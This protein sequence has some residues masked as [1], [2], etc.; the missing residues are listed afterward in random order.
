MIGRAVS[1]GARIPHY[2]GGGPVPGVGDP[3]YDDLI[4][5]FMAQGSTAPPGGTMLFDEISETDAQIGE[6]P[7]IPGMIGVDL[8]NKPLGDSSLV[9]PGN[10]TSN[11][12]I[13]FNPP[14]RGN[15]HPAVEAISWDAWF[16]PEVG[17]I[18]QALVSDD[19]VF[20]SAHWNWYIVRGIGGLIGLAT[21]IVAS[22]TDVPSGS[23]SAV[24]TSVVP[25]NTWTHVAIDSD[26]LGNVWLYINGVLE[27]TMVCSPTFL[28]SI[29]SPT[30]F[31]CQNKFVFG[32][33]RVLTGRMKC[34]RL[35]GRM[36][37][38]GVAFTPPASVAEYGPL[39][40]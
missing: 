13:S 26:G 6:T 1:A 22:P 37:W 9:F 14:A 3:F 39:A 35:T 23:D 25:L 4:Y 21:S 2:I 27:D 38:G 8:A 12:Y 11:N 29:E 40:A 16:N 5:L 15:V 7:F 32:F 20:G 17:G 33:D 28:S 10:V 36:R 24:S 30:Y 18:V 19:T 31:G 34:M